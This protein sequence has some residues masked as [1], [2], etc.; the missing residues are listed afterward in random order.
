MNTTQLE[1]MKAGFAREILNE[2]DESL[3]KKVIAFF[4]REK[5]VLET[6]PCRYTPEEIRDSANIAIRQRK[7]GHHIPHEEMKRIIENIPQ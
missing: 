2:Q 4:A 1:A 5:Q 3:I 7:E 6:P